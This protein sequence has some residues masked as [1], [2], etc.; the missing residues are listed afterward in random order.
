MNSNGNIDSKP[1]YNK[2]L[3]SYD[4]FIKS[5]NEKDELWDSSIKKVIKSSVNH[6]ERL[7]KTEY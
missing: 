1:V 3:E 5:F 2:N 4:N 7:K 6:S